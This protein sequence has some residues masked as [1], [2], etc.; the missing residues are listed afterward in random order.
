MRGLTT[1]TELVIGDC[2]GEH[3]LRC[4]WN[5]SSLKHLT[6][7]EV[8]DCC[9]LKYVFP[10]RILPSLAQLK[11]LKISGCEELEEIIT[12]DIDGND[13]ILFESHLL[14]LSF[15]NLCEIQVRWCNKL[16][17]V[18]PVAMAASLPR[19]QK[20]RVSEAPQL[21]EVF[22]LDDKTACLSVE[23]EVW[24]PNLIELSLEHLPSLVRFSPAYYNFVFPCLKILTVIKC[25][26]MAT[27][28]TPAA[29]DVVIA[30]SEV[31][32]LFWRH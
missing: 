7:L 25:P 13:Q 9:R 22:G 14:S 29:D 15:S 16:K 23:K 2:K 3:E 21:M 5:G 8:T 19:L 18:F 4:I 12:R 6:N 17:T 10:P 30:K 28:F 20:L 31:L 27:S 1:L 26:K 24:V 32:A 11:S